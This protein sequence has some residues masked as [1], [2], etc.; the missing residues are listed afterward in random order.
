VQLNGCSEED[1][2]RVYQQT[3]ASDAYLLMM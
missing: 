1:G 2:G 3:A